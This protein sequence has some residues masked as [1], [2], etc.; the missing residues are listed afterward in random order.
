MK[1]PSNSMFTYF[2]AVFQ[3]PPSFLR[4]QGA[5]GVIW[6]PAFAGMTEKT[7]TSSQIIFVIKKPVRRCSLL[8]FDIRSHRNLLKQFDDIPV[9]HANT[10][11]GG[12]LTD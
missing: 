5:R 6:I 11:M 7:W 10:A 12:W 8:N 1:Y 4:R 9:I 2:E 3:K